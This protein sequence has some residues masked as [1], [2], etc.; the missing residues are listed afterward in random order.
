MTTW[1]KTNKITDRLD[2]LFIKT[3]QDLE[4]ASDATK[5]LLFLDLCA[6]FDPH[7]LSDR[8]FD[9][10]RDAG[11]DIS[12]HD[13]YVAIE[14]PDGSVL[15]EDGCGYA[16]APDEQAYRQAM[17]LD[18][19]SIPVTTTGA[20]VMVVEGGLFEGVYGLVGRDAIVDDPQRGRLYITEGLSPHG[21][22]YHWRGGYA[23]KVGPDTTL[24]EAR[25]LNPR[26]PNVTIVQ[27]L[28]GEALAK[29]AGKLFN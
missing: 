28:Y 17:D 5:A 27:E 2:E 29:Y 24:K 7:G 12:P 11:T 19:E 21:G 23:I 10:V 13:Q 3:R 22:C 18:L 25:H 6:Y 8:V 4:D 20:A 26:D 14:Y 9:L 15:Y 16:T 1:H